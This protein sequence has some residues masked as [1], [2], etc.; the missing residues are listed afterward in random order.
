MRK[1]VVR[2]LAAIAAPIAVWAVLRFVLEVTDTGGR[3]E[4][5]VAFGILTLT[6]LLAAIYLLTRFVTWAAR[7]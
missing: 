7:H 4:R 1:V 3:T 2:V 6:V 5:Y